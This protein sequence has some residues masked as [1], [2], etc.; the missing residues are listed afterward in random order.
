MFSGTKSLVF[1]FYGMAA[2]CSLEIVCTTCSDV[3]GEAA[4][5]A[6]LNSLAQSMI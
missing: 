6:K 2:D 4:A 5:P 3:R 1:L